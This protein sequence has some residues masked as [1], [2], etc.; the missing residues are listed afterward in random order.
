MK[1][2]GP[3]TFRTFL[4]EV[5]ISACEANLKPGTV[6]TYRIYAKK[7]SEAFG[8]KYLSAISTNDVAKC[9]IL[10][11]RWQDVVSHSVLLP[12]SQL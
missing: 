10:K 8:D 11:L 1:K 9:E 4:D 6:E 3:T 12:I 2:A 5:S 7:T